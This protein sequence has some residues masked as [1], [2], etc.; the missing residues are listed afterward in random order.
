MQLSTI[1]FTRSSARHFFERLQGARVARVLD[2]RLNNTSQLAG[3]AKR[4]DLAFL[5]DA[6]AGVGYLHLTELAPTPDQLTRYRRGELDWNDYAAAYIDLLR[7]R[8]VET[9]LDASLFDGACLLCSEPT[10]HRCHRRLAAEYLSTHWP[11]IE[12]RHL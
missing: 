10:P 11:G 6:I 12:L 2:V 9:R 1:G 7:M 4:D 3:F 8:E 5:L